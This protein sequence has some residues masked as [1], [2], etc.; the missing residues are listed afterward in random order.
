MYQ[1]IDNRTEAA[2]IGSAGPLLFT[3]FAAAWSH[4][5]NLN[6]LTGE[7]RWYAEKTMNTQTDTESAKLARLRTAFAAF[8]E[9][10]DEAIQCQRDYE[11]EPLHSRIMR[12]VDRATEWTWGRGLLLG[13]LI[14]LIFSGGLRTII[15]CLTGG[16]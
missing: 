2:V 4:L 8:E 12:R 10:R 11:A 14:V 16:N 5:D 15:Q 7:M 9:A 3:S 1:I 6:T 13:G